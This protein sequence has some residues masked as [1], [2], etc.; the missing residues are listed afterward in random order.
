MN[1]TKETV[2]RSLSSSVYRVVH[3][4]RHALTLT[5]NDDTDRQHTNVYHPCSKYR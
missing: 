3:Q 4:S 5:E 1:L 2:K